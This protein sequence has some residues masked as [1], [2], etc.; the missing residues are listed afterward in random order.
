MIFKELEDEK[1]LSK[2]AL[3]EIQFQLDDLYRQRDSSDVNMANLV[4]K[5]GLEAVLGGP[6]VIKFA[7]NEFFDILIRSVEE[8]Q[9]VSPPSLILQLVIELLRMSC[10]S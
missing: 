5:I 9:D 2:R 6:V 10:Y 1:N 3:M 4:Y 8:W 7:V